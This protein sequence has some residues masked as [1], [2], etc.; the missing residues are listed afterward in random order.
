MSNQALLVMDFQP[1]TLA[2]VGG[3]TGPVLAAAA[4]AVQAAR[5]ARVPA[6]FV[7]V[8]FRPGYPEVS[9]EN[10]MMAALPRSGAVFVETEPTSRIHSAFHVGAEDIVVTKRRVGAFASDLAAVLAG[11]GVSRLV[12]AGVTTGGVVLSTVRQ[13]ADADYELTV[14]GDACADRTLVCTSSSWTGSS[15]PRRTS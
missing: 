4:A 7:R 1:A 12:L 11:L 3:D 8:A 2:A 10:K 5:H 13:A 6:V 15:P 9:A 14:L